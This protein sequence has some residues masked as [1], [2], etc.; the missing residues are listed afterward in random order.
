[1]PT[2]GSARASQVIPTRV[3]GEP[4]A[5]PQTAVLRAHPDAPTMAECNAACGARYG[6]LRLMAG[7]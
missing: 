6:L 1:M 5:R 3:G 2:S 4:Q 7:R